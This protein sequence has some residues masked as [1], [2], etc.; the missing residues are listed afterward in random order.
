[1]V[2]WTASYPHI[3]FYLCCPAMHACWYPRPFHRTSCNVPSAVSAMFHRW[4]VVSVLLLLFPF[5]LSLFS[6]LRRNIGSFRLGFIDLFPQSAPVSALLSPRS[7]GL[8][9]V[10]HSPIFCALRPILLY[11]K[12]VVDVILNCFFPHD[13]AF[14]GPSHLSS[15]MTSSSFPA[16]G[17]CIGV[18]V[19]QGKV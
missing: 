9:A 15:R 12:L 2:L 6:G 17:V 14:F 11:T 4:C 1:M 19:W 7:A 16:C 5:F 13:S 3:A 18:W 8:F 10:L